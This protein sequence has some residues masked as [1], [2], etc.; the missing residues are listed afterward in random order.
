M[1]YKSKK[2]FL[3][4]QNERPTFLEKML[5]LTVKWQDFVKKCFEKLCFLDPEPESEQKHFPKSEP[6][7]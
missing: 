3:K 6:E 4:N 5:L 7:P 1:E 2:M